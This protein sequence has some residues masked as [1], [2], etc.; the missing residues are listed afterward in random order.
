M[1]AR[2]CATTAEAVA[3]AD[4]Y[5]NNVALPNYSDLLDLLQE[6]LDNP[7]DI[8]QEQEEIRGILYGAGR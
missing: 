2:H 7:D 1:T 6:M 4:A 5:L 8:I 3:N